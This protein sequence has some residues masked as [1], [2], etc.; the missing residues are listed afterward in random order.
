LEKEVE[1]FANDWE[2][3]DELP[4]EIFHKLSNIGYFGLV[5]P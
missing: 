1:P 5:A 2:K 4:R 3:K